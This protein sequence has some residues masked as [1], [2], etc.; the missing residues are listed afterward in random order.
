M[1]RKVDRAPASRRRF[2]KLI[3]AGSVA[4]LAGTS[5][6]LAAASSKPRARAARARPAATPPTSR[7]IPRAVAAEIRNQK[8]Y[9]AR[10]LKT[11]RDYPLPA[12][13]AMAFRFDPL[14]AARRG[15]TAA[16]RPKPR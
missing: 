5:R 16:R 13:S 1:S 3:A 11:L 8:N 15:R 14:E 6:R 10:A 9:V 4:A 7:P 12:G 2:L